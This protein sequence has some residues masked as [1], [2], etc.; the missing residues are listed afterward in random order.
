MCNQILGVLI[1]LIKEVYSVYYLLLE[2]CVMKLLS[3]TFM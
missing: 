2:F 1:K 3:F